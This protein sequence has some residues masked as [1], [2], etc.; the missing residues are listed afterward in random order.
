M[1]IMYV[2]MFMYSYVVHV[3]YQQQCVHPKIYILLVCIYYTYQ[4][5]AAANLHPCFQD[6]YIFANELSKPHA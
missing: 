6:F 5:Y 1:L 2:A 3:Y 4:C